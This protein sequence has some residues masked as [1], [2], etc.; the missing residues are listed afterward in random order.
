MSDDVEKLCD[1]AT[2]QQAISEIFN[3]M[4][5]LDVGSADDVD[6][7][8]EDA[9]IGDSMLGVISFSGQYE[10]SGSAGFGYP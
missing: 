6:G 7:V 2:L 9:P 8:D 5:F 1:A 3:T 4:I 10:G